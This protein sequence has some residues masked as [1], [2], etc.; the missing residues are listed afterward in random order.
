MLNMDFW[1]LAQSDGLVT[2][3]LESCTPEMRE[4][5]ERRLDRLCKTGDGHDR[6]CTAPLDNGLY[7]LRGRCGKVHARLIFIYDPNVRKRIIFVHACYKEKKA[8]W[9]REQRIAGKNR[10]AVI[11][12]T[13]GVRDFNITH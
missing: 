6:P 5:L 9:M 1:R 2:K 4:I 8:Q 3:F 13:G 7:E 12:A 10:D 11:N